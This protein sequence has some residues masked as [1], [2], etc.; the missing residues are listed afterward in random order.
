MR[1][2]PLAAL[3]AA[4]VLLLLGASACT[5]SSAPV[6]LGTVDRSSV[7]E[8][9]DASATITAHAVATLTAPTAGTL[10]SLSVA[11]GQSVAAG[12]VVAVIDSPA[13][14]Q[15]LADAS[16]ALASASGGA[17]GGGLNTRDLAAAQKRTDDAAATAFAAARRA[18][19]A[20]ADP[21]VRAGLLAQIDAASAQYDTLAATSRAL[22]ASVQRGI[23]SLSSA[24]G[25]LG[26]AQRAQARAAYNLA[27]STVDALTLRAPI[28]GVVQLGGPA[29]APATG[30]LSNLLSSVAGGVPVPVPASGSR[31]TGPGVDDS[32]GLGEP[33]GAGTAVAT[34]VDTSALGLIADID[35]TD[36]LL[37]APGVPAQVELDAAPGASYAATVGSVDVLPTTSARGGVAYRAR[38][39]LGAGRYSDGRAAPTPRPGM[40]AVAHLSVREA[41]DAVTVP[42]AAV[43]RADGRD[44]VWLVRD[45][46]EVRVPVTLGVQG[47]DR[48]Q[49]VSGV[50]AGDRV[51]VR[52]AD[53]VHSG[54]SL[55]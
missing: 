30:S 22:V 26:A 43:V 23:A 40:S 15:Q 9:V 33:V 35:E 28:A 16:A 4:V 13:A 32:V 19:T 39:T 44:A 10:A 50:T 53:R 55:P 34:I 51:V 14:Q 48:V 36:V 49:V 47:P 2:A 42:A 31:P 7:T 46:K 6:G 29:S 45:G 5:S 54:Q 21:G 17:G 24:L 20:I 52:G 11:P 3:T 38:L 27:K 41:R 37:V 12:Q 25:A 8:V 1:R 18:A